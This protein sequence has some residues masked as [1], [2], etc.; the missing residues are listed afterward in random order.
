MT[1][2]ERLNSIVSY[3]DYLILCNTILQKIAGLTCFVI[4]A[5]RSEELFGTY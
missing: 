2:A 3:G 1:E 5:L 4:A